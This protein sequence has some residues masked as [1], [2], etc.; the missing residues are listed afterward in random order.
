LT[1]TQPHESDSIEEETETDTQWTDKT[2]SQTCA[3]LVH[4]C[5]GNGRTL[6]PQTTPQ[7]RPNPSTSQ[8]QVQNNDHWLQKGKWM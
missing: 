1:K 2:Q 8:L 5:I 4:M 6:W 3:P 7:G